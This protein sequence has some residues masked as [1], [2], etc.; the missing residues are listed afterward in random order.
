MGTSVSGGRYNVAS[1]DYSSVTGGGSS[2]IT[3]SN[4]ASGDYSAFTGGDDNEAYANSSSILGGR[5]NLTGAPSSGDRTIAIV[6][7]V[8]GG[9]DNLTQE[10]ASSVSGGS[11]YLASGEYDW[12][13]GGLFETQ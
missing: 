7:S 5:R 2:V 13:A 4:T 10:N 8:G 1:G 9:V 6:S 11:E 12:V 3:G